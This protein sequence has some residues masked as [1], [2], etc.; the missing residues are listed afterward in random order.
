MIEKLE[1]VKPGP[2]HGSAYLAMVDEHLTYG[3]EY[4]YNNIELART[5]FAAFVRELE[6]EAQGIGLPPGFPA[7]QTYLLLKDGEVVIGEIRFRPHLEP[8]YERFNG[9]SGYNVR[10]SYRGKG[11]GTRQLAL[12][13]A[14]TRKWDL[15]GISFT[16][17]DENPA[18]VRII[19]K[20]GGRLLYVKNNPI[21]ACLEEGQGELVVRDVV[22]EG[23][24]C[25]LYWI[26][27]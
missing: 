9:H 21:L 16:I 3:E 2:E 10:P 19:E 13:L 22:M 17:E 8:P 15:P 23:V 25:S 12:L 24:R 20:N 26:D 6:E 5:N 7:Q 27:L 1:L 18:S 11:Y 14:E 4:N